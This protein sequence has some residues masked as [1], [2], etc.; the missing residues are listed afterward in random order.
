MIESLFNTQYDVVSVATTSDSKGGRTE[1]LSVGSTIWGLI[2][3][4]SAYE[5]SRFG[6]TTAEVTN[7]VVPLA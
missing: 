3:P 1:T 5:A 4:V 7:K 2:V 6:K